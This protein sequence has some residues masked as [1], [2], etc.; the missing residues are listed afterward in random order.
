MSDLTLRLYTLARLERA[1]RAASPASRAAVASS[2][3]QSATVYPSRRGG[4][5]VPASPTPI[6]LTDDQLKRLTIVVGPLHPVER[7]PFLRALAILMGGHGEIGDGEFYRVLRELK[8]QH[9]NP[10]G[11]R[12]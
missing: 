9:V 7:E 6:S 3:P 1:R 11:D 2:R 12:T 4:G 5:P 8:R 10:P